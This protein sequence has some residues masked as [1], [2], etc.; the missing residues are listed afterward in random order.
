MTGIKRQVRMNAERFDAIKR[1]DGVGVDRRGI[2]R[3]TKY[4]VT[5]INRVLRCD[6]FEAY[7]L[8]VAEFNKKYNAKQ[9][10]AEEP[11]TEVAET[12]SVPSVP[13]TR[14]PDA[15]RT[16]FSN[17]ERMTLSLER[18]ADQMERLAEAWE[19]EAT[20]KA[21]KRFF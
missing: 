3:I 19:T 7:R 2:S 13:G 11:S 12:V 4:S 17:E 15:I 14:I 9:A 21:K 5:T 20:I 18:I 16:R 1:L 6:N 8:D 10:V